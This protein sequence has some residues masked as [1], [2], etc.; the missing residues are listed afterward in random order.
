MKRNPAAYMHSSKRHTRH[1][2]EGNGLLANG[3]KKGRV[4]RGKGGRLKGRGRLNSR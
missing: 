2:L 3:P 4:G 1:S